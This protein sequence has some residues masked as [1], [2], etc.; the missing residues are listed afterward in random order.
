MPACRREDVQVKLE[1][2]AMAS[3]RCE[4]ER[5]CPFLR[6][7]NNLPIF[8]IY[9]AKKDVLAPLTR[10]GVPQGPFNLSSRSITRRRSD[11]L[12]LSGQM[13]SPLT[14][15]VSP[16]RG[17]QLSC[18]ILGRKLTF[19]RLLFGSPTREEPIVRTHPGDTDQQEPRL[20]F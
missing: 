17:G 13:L 14:P 3:S 1:A 19:G 15:L 5:R 12:F 16:P 4:L 11:G 7:W 10:G 18:G 20:T 8:F 6:L 2:A 9:E